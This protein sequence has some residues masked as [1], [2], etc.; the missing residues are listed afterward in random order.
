MK[1]TKKIEAE[2]KNLEDQ[3]LQTYEEFKEKTTT[4]NLSRL[5][6]AWGIWSTNKELFDFQSKMNDNTITDIYFTIQD[7]SKDIL[8]W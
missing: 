2:F 6:I 3:L 1:A 5:A 4:A 8:I 7:F